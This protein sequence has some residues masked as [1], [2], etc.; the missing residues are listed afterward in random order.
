MKAAGLSLILTLFAYVVTAQVWPA[1]G[2]KLNYRLVTFTVPAKQGNHVYTLKVARGSYRK[3]E[4]FD[5][6]VQIE[7]VETNNRIVAE[8]P[9]FD[10]PYTWQVEYEDKSKTALFHCYTKGSSMTDTSKYRLRVIENKY[11]TDSVYFFLDYARSL[12][13]MK[14]EIVWYLPDIIPY[15]DSV[16][17]IRDL[18]M[19]PS[20][21]ITFLTDTGAY[22][23]D[24]NGK[25]LWSA[26]EV[27][28]GAGLSYHHEFTK[29]N[30]GNYMLLGAEEDLRKMPEDSL[31][32]KFNGV[33]EMRDDGHYKR[34]LFS[35][36]EEFSPDKKLVWKWSS[37]NYFKGERFDLLRMDNNTYM[38][39]IKLNGF[40]FDEQKRIVYAGFRDVSQILKI[41]YPEG[42]ILDVYGKNTATTSAGAFIAQHSYNITKN[43]ELLIYNNNSQR[44]D[45]NTISSIQIFQEPHRQGDSLKKVWEFSCDIDG[46]AA[47]Q[48]G[49]EGNVTELSDGSILCCMGTSPRIFIVD[50]S[51]NILFNCI[52]EKWSYRKNSWDKYPQYR[53]S[54]LNI[55]NLTKAIN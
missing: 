49:R 13:N 19:T 7:R 8:L 23:V 18:K 34:I 50:R 55:N 48:S 29:L 26:P 1:E 33:L 20:G 40:Y 53:V 47:R 24:Y 2:S 30:N 36:I 54:I 38:P 15:V 12:Y 3:Q 28:D 14:G 51:K 9:S 22:E 39:T 10:A 35:T 44:N 46:E 52:S 27:N 17:R 37:S 21:T 45:R 41:R 4:V 11:A 16:S 5:R 43:K 31:A 6:N 42:D 25:L 32:L